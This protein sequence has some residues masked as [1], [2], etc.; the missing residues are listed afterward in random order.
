MHAPEW[1][2]ALLST[3]E[4][5]HWIADGFPRNCLMQQH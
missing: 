2:D 4:V 5:L 3:D 1:P